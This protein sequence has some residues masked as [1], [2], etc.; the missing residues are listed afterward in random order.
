MNRSDPVMPLSIAS[1]ITSNTTWQEMMYDIYI[2]FVVGAA[3]SLKLTARWW[4]YH[5]I[6]PMAHRVMGIQLDADKYRIE[7]KSWTEENRKL[8]VV[9]VGYGR[10]GTVRQNGHLFPSPSLSYIVVCMVR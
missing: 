7:S 10:T 8:Q 4:Y 5:L 1:S 6:V 3:H 2:G 9:A